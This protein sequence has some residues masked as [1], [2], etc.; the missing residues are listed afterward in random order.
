M[1][2]IEGEGM[3]MTRMDDAKWERW[4]AA[5]GI[6]AFVLLAV[7][8]F[9]VTASPPK[10]TDSAQ[11]IVKFAVDHRSGLLAQV[12]VGG[13]GFALFFP[14]FLGSLRSFLAKAEGGTGRLA[15]VAFGGG[16]I[17]VG[18][19][20]IGALLQASV[21]LT[22]AKHGDP[23]VVQALFVVANT[24]FVLVGYP[25]AVLAGATAFVAL[26]HGALPRWYA[27]ASGLIA[28]YALFTTAGILVE[29]GPLSPTGALQFI[30][31]I[32]FGLWTLVTSILLVQRVGK[33]PATAAMASAPQM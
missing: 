8:N 10:I 9:F 33:A 6:A 26:R 11:K 20:A 16:L 13:F 4:A 30:G 32:L 5:T 2:S 23:G 7:S 24:G 12:F 1:L 18:T 21:A 25:L 27:W 22:I 15:M 29:T 19:A 3:G 14:W 31:F 28:L 17:L